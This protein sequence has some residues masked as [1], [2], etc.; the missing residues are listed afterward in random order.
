MLLSHT[1]TLPLP[2]G[3][4]TRPRPSLLKQWLPA[5]PQLAKAVIR[6]L[7]QPDGWLSV[8]DWCAARGDLVREAEARRQAAFLE[9]RRNLGHQSAGRVRIL[10]AEGL[11]VQLSYRWIEAGKP[12]ALLGWL[13]LL[14]LQ[15]LLRAKP[16]YLVADL[17]EMS[18]D[19][20]RL[21][22]ARAA[23]MLFAL[24]AR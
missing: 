22:A 15:R 12:P 13:H 11:A 16:V 4:W 3:R 17:S 21:C 20:L 10:D 6:K 14:D 19:T 7:H 24:P 2:M 18:L 23:S 8:A 9:V 5:A 1:T